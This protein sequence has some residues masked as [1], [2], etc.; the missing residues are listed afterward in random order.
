MLL[1]CLFDFLGVSGVFIGNDVWGGCYREGR[2]GGWGRLDL[3]VFYSVCFI[4]LVVCI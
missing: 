1:L 3:F 2:R 4:C